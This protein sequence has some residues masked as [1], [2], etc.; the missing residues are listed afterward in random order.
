MPLVSL[1]SNFIHKT[2]DK[3]LSSILNDIKNGAYKTQ[4]DA[5]QKMLNQGNNDEA[6]NLKKQLPA[7]TVSGTFQGGRSVDK[8]EEYNQFVIL[9]I[10]KLSAPQIK[11]L[12]NM[13]F[14][15]PYTYAVFISP[16]GKGL[17]IIVKVDSEIIRH[18]QAF[19]QVVEYYEEA[20]NINIDI[21]GSDISRL[22]FMSFDADCIIK[23]NFEIF[24]VIDKPKDIEQPKQVTY[25][26]QDDKIEKFIEEIERTQTDITQGY[27]NWRNLGFALAD[28]YG[29]SGRNY[30]HRISRI[31]P[32][33]NYKDC[34]I[35]YTRCLKSNGSGYKISTFYYMVFQSG[36]RIPYNDYVKEDTNPHYLKSPS[37]SDLKNIEVVFEKV[38]YDAVELMTMGKIEPK[39]LMFPIFPQKGTAILVG[40]PDTGKSQFARQLCIEVALGNKEFLN[41]PLTLR[42]SKSIYVATEDNMEA[43]Q[44]LL[45]KQLN[46]L[47]KEAEENLKFIFADTMSQEEILKCLDDELLKHP[48]DLV[49]VDSFSDIFSGKDNNNNMAMRNTVKIFDAIAK[50]HDCLILFV[51]HINKGAYKQAPGQEHIQG[52][53]G[54]TQKARLAVQLSEGEGNTRYFTVVKGNYCPKEYKQ[55]SLV[56][57]FSEDNFLFT[58]TGK[59]IPTD[60]LG[61]K[62]ES[63]KK[64]DKYNDLLNIAIAIFKGRTV[65]SYGN[66]V[67]LYSDI[68]G[69]S[70]PTAKRNIKMMVEFE[71]LLK[72]GTTYAIN[73]EAIK[74]EDVNN[75]E[76]NDDVF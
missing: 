33:Y 49:V 69:K 48:S 19:S 72:D 30:F 26:N 4:V 52:G 12:K 8:I 74:N 73:L 42:H 1:F 3:P 59:L 51:H 22:C 11:E 24:H 39:Y 31:N 54:L 15:A 53:S 45:S 76:E 28:E 14:L 9:D 43:T 40:K 57:E 65:L 70:A 67:K 13:A 35:Q 34:D 61:V 21:S 36:I 63:T 27:E 10:D 50:K 41:F 29:E 18:K 62:D 37:N 7:F 2:D 20:L 58:N 46:G 71:I 17:K 75:N 38:V 47:H 64:E 55:N 5:I 23:E 60:D 6:S 66:I 16:S 44:Y 25:Y 56:L 68:T 32:D